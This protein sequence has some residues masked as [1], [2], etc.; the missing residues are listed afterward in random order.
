MD[1]IMYDELK[2]IYD[3]IRSTMPDSEKEDAVIKAYDII[4]RFQHVARKEGLLALEEE[5]DTLDP[6]DDTQAY[7]HFLI[8]L[9]V[10]GTDPQLIAEIGKNRCLAMHLPAYDGLMCLMY[11]Q[12][13]MLI[14]TGNNPCVIDTYMQSML[15]MSILKKLE[16]K[17]HNTLREL[18]DTEK[19]D[20]IKTLCEDGKEIDEKDHSV[21]NQT[22][23]TLIS[24]SDRD[25]QRLLREIANTDIEIAMKALPGKA[26]K[27]I[28][29][30]MS[31]RLGL[32]VAEDM[33]YMGPVRRR[34]AEEGC[35]NI[36]KVLIKLVDHGEVAD[37]D[38]TMSKVV[39]DVYEHS[40]KA[41]EELKNRYKDLKDAI[42]QIYRS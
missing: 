28:F 31:H 21:V 2:R 36:M 42:D 39:L 19:Q 7:F 14:Q 34:D 1:T 30:N 35:V 27:R 10:D 11:Y 6:N 33:E 12:A 26:R 40:Q 8:M 24:L 37:Y 3:D 32:M 23:M 13:V 5:C 29:D 18:L 38:M 9:I 41:N 20:N 15:P 16:M 25:V 17:D 22:A 4:M